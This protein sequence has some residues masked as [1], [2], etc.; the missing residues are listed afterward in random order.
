MISTIGYIIA[1]AI[2]IALGI[3]LIFTFRSSSKLSETEK[4]DKSSNSLQFFILAMFFLTVSIVIED[5]NVSEGD[6]ITILQFIFVS[7]LIC[8][9][10]RRYNKRKK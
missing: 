2:I 4:Q 3:R 1:F 9:I 5:G 7:V 8:L 6:I 10:I